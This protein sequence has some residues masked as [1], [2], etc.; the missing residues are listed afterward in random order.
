MTARTP[1]VLL[2]ILPLAL[3]AC[4]EA[5][6]TTYRIPKEASPHSHP[7]TA[8]APG[9]AASAMPDTGGLAV[10]SSEAGG[11]TWT[12]PAAWKAQPGSAVRKGSY[13]IGEAGGPTA[14]LAITAFPGDVGGDLANI[15][16]W[17]GQ[18]A[19]APITAA[20]LPASLTPLSVAGLEMKVADLAGGTP[21]APIRMLGAIVPHGNGT[22]FFKLTGPAEVVAREKPAFLAFL[23]TVKVA[24]QPLGAPVATSPS[25]ATALP[26]SAPTAAPPADMSGAPVVTSAGAGLKWSAPAHWQSKPAT[27]TRKA[28][29]VITNAK[30]SAELAVTAFPGD[31]GGDLANL[32]RWRGQLGLPPVSDAEFPAAVT[33][34][35]VND[36]AITVADIAA[37]GENA[38]RLLGAMVPYAGST[39]FFKLTGP[40]AL[41]AEE[42]PAFLA[43]LQTLSAP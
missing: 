20:E 35:K 3:T 43:F 8:T 23:Q 26:A 37:T 12:A 2:L 27:T 33:R 41:V 29:F 13:V 15:N 19:L 5:K 24:A 6:V 14:D 22:W 34:L 9:D 30:G 40:A 36:L 1:R 4:R 32:N 31:V 16:R 38:P 7:A 42:K 18:V 25:P 11:L 28:T 21:D 17:R 39:W 10:V